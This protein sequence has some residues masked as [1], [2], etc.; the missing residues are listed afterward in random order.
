MSTD[1]IR[2][3]RPALHFSP[4]RGWV[5]DP[6]GLVFIDG[7]WHLFAQH[8]PVAPVWG[9]M[10][11]AHAVSGDL[12]HW[13][14]LPIAL[15]P[16]QLGMIFS[17]SA[18]LDTQ[19]SSGFAIGQ[20]PPLVA[21]YTSHGE[22][23]EQSIAYSEDYVNFT[24]YPGNPV[25]PN[26]GLQDFRDPKLFPRPRGGWGMVLAAGDRVHF[27]ASQD[28]IHWEKTGEFGPEGNFSQGVWECPDLFPLH[29]PDGGEKWVLL[30]S[31]G[32][33]EEN[34]GGRTQYFLGRYDGERFQSDS[35]FS[36]PE[37]LD[38]GLDLYAAVTYANAPRRILLG[39]QAN[40]VYAHFLP[41]G[42][43]CCNFSLPRELRLEETAFG[44]R[45]AALPI[46]PE[47]GGECPAGSLSSECF[48]LRASGHGPGEIRLENSSGRVLALG[49]DEENRVYLDRSR[50][51]SADFSPVFAS[52]GFQRM[53]AS[54]LARGDWELCLVLD[55][56]AAELF[57]DGGTRAFSTL[58]FPEEP[59][60]RVQAVGGVSG[61]T[62]RALPE[63]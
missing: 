45:L 30:V 48:V 38:Q 49:V 12:L 16:D 56:C 40:P 21:M 62:V 53:E 18:V 5:N 15:A 9:P 28:L 27:Y 29:A 17:G 57:A 35:S 24:K 60:S 7:Q 50:A 33:N 31:N 39:W 43:Y 41:T 4:K 3:F 55:H 51:G 52:Q 54:R 32:P 42:D 61:L 44:L 8:N 58:V 2:D 20:R 1:A 47:A 6:N 14:H 13:E 59:Y 34:R 36:A 11:W 37:F 10:H 25:I 23:E 26:P 19:N 63:E 22:C 46:L